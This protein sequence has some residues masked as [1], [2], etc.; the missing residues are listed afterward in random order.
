MYEFTSY[1]FHV[2][3]TSVYNCACTLA[4]TPKLRFRAILVIIAFPMVRADD[5]CAII[6]C[7]EANIKIKKKRI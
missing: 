4:E 6:E 1:L 7:F 5:I 2:G 3:R